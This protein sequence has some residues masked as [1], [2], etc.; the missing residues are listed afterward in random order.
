MSCYRLALLFFV[1]Y[2]L[3]T[4]GLKA[5]HLPIDKVR[6]Q[7]FALDKSENAALL[8]FQSLENIDLAKDPLLLAYR[9]AASAAAA[10]SVSGVYRKLDYFN[11]G[12]SELDKAIFLDRSDPEIRF[13]RL[14]TQLKAPWFLGYRS[15][16]ESDKSM[17]LKT[18]VATPA[19]HPNAY[20]YQQIC[21]FLLAYADLEK[22]EKDVVNQLI[23]KFN[24]KL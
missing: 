14:A 17:L 5:Q 23:V 24:P 2:C 7:Y 21:R 22:S 18:L 4:H 6:M 10:G 11:R 20:L 8:L 3:S 12:K 15:D 13:L 1:L 9:G 16:I 19:N